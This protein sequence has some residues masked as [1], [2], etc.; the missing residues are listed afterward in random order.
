MSRP[1]SGKWGN[2]PLRSACP[3]AKWR[4][5]TPAPAQV[6]MPEYKLSILVEGADRGASDVLLHLHSG[7][8]ALNVA[9]GSLVADGLKAATGALLDFGKQGLDVAMDYQGSMNMFQA[10][11]GATGDQ[12]A[13]IGA[14]AKRLG[15]DMTLP[16]TSAGDAAK[17]M[18]E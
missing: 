16:A 7:L 17:A 15:A 2:S 9:L 12:M 11:S 4:R 1:R 5:P 13:Q 8:G 6:T 3:P 14:E 18:T 10:V